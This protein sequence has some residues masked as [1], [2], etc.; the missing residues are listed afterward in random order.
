MA[1]FI[2]R[3]ELILG[4]AAAAFAPNAAQS[5]TRAYTVD[6]Y[7]YQPDG[8]YAPLGGRNVNMDIG[9]LHPQTG[10]ATSG[11]Y[12]SLDPYHGTPFGSLGWRNFYRHRI[13]NDVHDT[14]RGTL[15]LLGQHITAHGI[16]VDEIVNAYNIAKSSWD[17]NP[18]LRIAAVNTL[19]HRD[20]RFS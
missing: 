12:A 2:T 10:G 15:L 14:D 9:L 5:Q 7:P 3:R 13:G 20:I 18:S 11:W 1:E 19:E 17:N 4:A 16:T 8:V 6:N